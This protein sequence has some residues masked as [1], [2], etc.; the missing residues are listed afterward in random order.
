M[1]D[2]GE[3]W[4]ERRRRKPAKTKIKQSEESITLRCIANASPIKTLKDYIKIRQTILAG[5]PLYNGVLYGMLATVAQ[6]VGF[7]EKQADI[8]PGASR[9]SDLVIEHLFEDVQA[10]VQPTLLKEWRNAAKL[11]SAKLSIER[12]SEY[13]H[14]SIEISC[15]ILDADNVHETTLMPA[16]SQLLWEA[17][18]W[19]YPEGH[20]KDG[21]IHLISTGKAS[22]RLD[23]LFFR[24]SLK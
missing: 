12:A 17:R 18:D 6:E 13:M 7:K 11:A 20:L 23:G 2:K 1:I 4:G 21:L 19:I 15:K 14:K 22:T 8:T 10:K 9:N 5:K 3:E 24:Y 16:A